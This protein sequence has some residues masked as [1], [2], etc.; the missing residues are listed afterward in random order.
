MD[1]EDPGKVFENSW[2]SVRCG[3]AEPGVHA[4]VA[5]DTAA[6]ETRVALRAAAYALI[7]VGKQELGDDILD[8]LGRVG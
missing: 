1:S 7:A 3:L 5:M 8:T 6:W 4:V 2:E